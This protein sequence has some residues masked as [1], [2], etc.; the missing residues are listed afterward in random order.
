[1]RS[2]LWSNF[3]KGPENS[4]A[5]EAQQDEIRQNIKNAAFFFLF[6]SVRKERER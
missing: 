6:Q 3:S 4:D 1:M 5:L 2:S